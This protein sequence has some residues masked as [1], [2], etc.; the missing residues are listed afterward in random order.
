M[1]AVEITV[2]QRDLN[3]AMDVDVVDVILD[4]EDRDR[5]VEE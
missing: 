2:V 5:G 1:P 3:S 4:E